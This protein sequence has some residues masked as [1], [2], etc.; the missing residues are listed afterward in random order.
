MRTKAIFAIVLAQGFA[1][2]VGSLLGMSMTIGVDA[3][4]FEAYVN[5]IRNMGLRIDAL[6][7]RVTELEARQV[8]SVNP[9]N[10]EAP[11]NRWETVGP[12][13]AWPVYH[14]KIPTGWLINNNGKFI[15]FADENHTW[16]PHWIKTNNAT[17]PKA[18]IYRTRIPGGWLVIQYTDLV[19]V[20]DPNG[21]W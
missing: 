17:D 9:T 8:A 14:S 15:T 10:V 16:A 12:P 7:K 19:W 5:T 1:L 18:T 4:Q 21:T 6:Q 2:L 3:S 13:P 11:E 20:P